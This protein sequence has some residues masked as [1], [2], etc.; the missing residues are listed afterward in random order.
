MEKAIERLTGH[1]IVCGAGKT[2][3]YVAEE[4]RKMGHPFVMVDQDA[5]QLRQLPWPD[6]L[7]VQGDAT[8]EAVLEEAGI[9]R[10]ASLVAALHT[11]RD[12]LF[13]VLTARGLNARLR[14]IAKGV[15]EESRDKLL[16]AGADSVVLE[17][18]IGGLR[19]AS[20]VIRPAVV[21]FLDIMLRD[22]DRT[23]RIEEARIGPGSRFIGTTVGEAAVH[24]PTG[25]ILL[26]VR[27]PDGRYHYA[28][29]ASIVL[30]E[31]DILIVFGDLEVLGRLR[32]LAGA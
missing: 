32:A 22:K 4:M 30:Q 27:R 16:R 5:E 25:L 20:E 1:A 26:A 21:S 12:N 3:W 15:E 29:D 2:G 14:I 9:H 10:A 24:H 6:V 18:F 8:K 28:P 11:D 23:L 17:Y 13:V 7:W 31:G 19:M